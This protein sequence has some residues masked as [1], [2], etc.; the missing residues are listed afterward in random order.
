M[1]SFTL[2]IAALLCSCVNH[3][4]GVHPLRPHDLATGPY[5]GVATAAFTGSLMYEGGC[6]LFRDEDNHMQLLPVWPFGSEFNGSLVTFHRPGK[7]EQRIAVNEEFQMEGRP[8]A[9]SA[10]P[11]PMR[12]QFQTQCPSEP[13]AVSAI[14][15]AN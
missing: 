13:F 6:L 9:W 7:T 15:P 3:G 14:R 8:V 12:E 2:I 1:R 10:L 5:Q 11:G 4:G